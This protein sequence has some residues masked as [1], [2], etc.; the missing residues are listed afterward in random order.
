MPVERIPGEKMYIDWVG[1]QPELL[2]DTSTGELQRVHIFTTTLGFSS[3]IYAEIF[4]DEKLPQFIAGT[5]HALSFY[6][7]VPKYLVPDNLKTAV[8]KH[9][10][11][12]LVL[13]SAFSDLE[14]FYDTIILPPPPRK[15][16]GKPTVENHVRFLETHLVEELKKETY[17]S[18]EALNAAARR[19]VADINR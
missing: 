17:T 1:D 10:K 2:L 16:K 18:L 3:L 4:L 5:V 11:D 13:Q 9:T 15:P 14:S 6:G 12:E 19:I 7:A 8:T